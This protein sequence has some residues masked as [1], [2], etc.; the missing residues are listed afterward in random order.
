MLAV[1]AELVREVVV[2]VVAEGVAEAERALRM[3]L[4]ATMVLQ[5]APIPAGVAAALRTLVPRAPE[6][7]GVPGS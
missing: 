6:G 3:L 2:L 7:A 5:E 4:E 1:V